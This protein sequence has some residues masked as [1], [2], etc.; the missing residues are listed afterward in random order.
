MI[1]FTIVAIIVVL[2]VI[3]MIALPMC[4][5][6][7]VTSST[8]GFDTYFNHDIGAHDI[9]SL[10]N[11]KLTVGESK[12]QAEYRWNDRDGEG[13]NVYDKFYEGEVL[14]RNAGYEPTFGGMNS[15]YD[16]ETQF[17][18]GA[19]SGTGYNLS[20]MSNNMLFANFWH[21]GMAPDQK[22]TVQLSEKIM[23]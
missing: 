1:T 19:Q 5:S 6:D 23:G 11:P 12:L 2:F 10:D 8:E 17:K 9:Y 20:E 13:E 3:L 4:G 22:Y 16:Y 7:A 15:G 18:N 14:Q 21:A